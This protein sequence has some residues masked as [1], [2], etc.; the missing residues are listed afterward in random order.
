VDNFV[1]RHVVSLQGR[2]G[3]FRR[4]KRRC[5][6]GRKFNLQRDGAAR[7]HGFQGAMLLRNPVTPNQMSS[8]TPARVKYLFFRPASLMV[9]S[10]GLR[11]ETPPAPLYYRS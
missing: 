9:G 1:I 3:V 2:K 6:S 7:S 4:A 5:P 8:A 11:L 10:A